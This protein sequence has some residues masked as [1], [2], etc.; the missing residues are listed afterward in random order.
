MQENLRR[1]FFWSAQIAVATV[2]IPA[3]LALGQ[4]TITPIVRSIGALQDSVPNRD[5]PF[6]FRGES[7][8]R[9]PA[10]N[11]TGEVVFRARSA[12]S[13]DNNAGAALGIYVQRP[14][15]PLAVIV[16]NLVDAGTPG[17]AVPGRP[18]GAFFLDFSAPLIND[19]GDVLFRALFSD[20]VGGT[21][22]G[23]YATTTSSGALTKIV[24]TFDLVPGAG[25]ATFQSFTFSS[26]TLQDLAMVAFNNAGQ[27]AFWATYNSFD[28]GLFGAT[29]SGG[30]IVQLADNTII[31][32]GVPFGTPQPFSE[33]R[34]EISINQSGQV[35]FHGSIR[36]N[37]PTGPIRNGLFRVPVVG[38]A[39]E[40][41]AFQ[42]VA[43]P[44]AGTATFS[45]FSDQDI[46]DSG[47][48]VFTA[49]L[50][51]GA[52]G[53]YATAMPGGP[54]TSIVDT[55]AGGVAVPGDIVGAEFDILRI[56]EITEDG[57]MGF[58][59]RIR[60][61]ATANNQGIYS[62]TVDATSIGLILDAAS[63]APG[64]T[65]PAR[66]TQYAD[67][68]AAINET[69]SMAFAG[70]GADETGAGNR[71]L[72]F[73]DACG[74]QVI[75]I[76]DSTTSLADLGGEFSPLGSQ[77]KK[78]SVFQGFASL[79]GRYNAVNDA[80]QV[81]FVAQFSNFDFGIYVAEVSA[82]AGGQIDITCPQDFVLECPAD[83]STN[84][85]GEAVA[86]DS[87]SGDSLPVS[88]TDVVTPDCGAAEL[89][90]RTWTADAG[91]GATV[92][93]DQVIDV[94]DT[95]APSLVGVPADAAVECDA[96]PAPATV[97]ASD[98]CDPSST[99]GFAEVQTAGDCPDAFSIQRTWT[100]SD[101]CGNSVAQSQ[102][103]TVD[104]TTA[105]VITCPAD[106][107][108]L[109]CGDDTGVAANGTAT[110]TDNCSTATVT[111]SDVT[112]SGCGA[113]VSVTRTFSASDACGNVS[114]CDQSIATNDNTPP[115]ISLSTNAV[116][117]VDVDCSGDESVMLP[118]A[119]AGDT[120]G[121]VTVSDDAPVSF[122][123]GES[124]A[125]TFTATDECGSTATDTAQVDVD[126]GS[127]IIVKAIRFVIG[128]G[129][130]PS[131]SKEPIP[132]TEVC[133]F[134]RSPGSCA[135]TMCPY[136]YGKFQCIVDNCEPVNCATTDENGI[137]SIDVPPGK[138][139]VI[140]EDLT[141]LFLPDP[142]GRRVGQVNCGETKIA[143][144]RQIVRNDGRRFACRIT[145]LTGS[146]LLIVEPEEMVWDQTV[147]EY[148]FV[149]ESVGD[150]DVTVGVEPPEGFVADTEAISENVANEDEAV[151]FEITEVGS[152]LVPT[153]TTFDVTHNGRKHLVTSSV[154]IKLTEKYARSR[155]FD[156]VQ[157]RRQGLIKELK[158]AK[159]VKPIDALSPL[160]PARPIKKESA[161]VRAE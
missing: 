59:A 115:T 110:A 129:R 106:Q 158:P 19:S 97:T 86:V 20:P 139:F 120:C 107:L 154:N 50:S 56:A 84:S 15:E 137:A 142:L 81:A 124:T 119:T 36:L 108:L 52:T 51:D 141:R 131:F 157:L 44:D 90:T 7:N 66:V 126:F 34:P 27:V 23:I 11:A 61:S 88:F 116:S 136:Y 31:P 118:A 4:V 16:D 160:R 134:D 78:L 159:S 8:V 113:T 123:A 121:S 45:T 2:L 149:F 41:V 5:A 146:E 3:V 96:I 54:F 85:L 72:Y 155:G 26:A 83:T 71:G 60:N 55:Q 29:V 76:V 138:Y 39:V 153:I 79:S 57:Q 1:R 75:R 35:A 64:L 80:N 104:D 98:A 132:D 128:F 68:S 63:T 122:P 38:G 53:I 62:A 10:I 156:P 112:S 161:A 111:S 18:A 117:V 140:A 33:I 94:N 148:P 135:E 82:G 145:R 9:L 95:V 105:P 91:G 24:D 65:D 103:V 125:V 12:S 92:S 49:G 6:V 13:F 32:T 28:T 151:Q 69:G 67:L 70:V 22:A 48:V 99:V 144:L 127:T 43:A 58:F 102:T 101:A 37:T 17:F 89:I 73:F 100:A 25:G 46:D 40:T 30:A 133:A 87:C 21:S 114:S 47:R 93:C 74:G 109:E 143:R 150:W 147:Q 130:R 77:Q 42:F 152:D 14:G